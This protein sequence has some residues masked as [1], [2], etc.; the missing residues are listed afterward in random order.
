[1]HFYVCISVVT[2]YVN[3][4]YYI[5]LLLFECFV[6]DLSINAGTS[7]NK[8]EYRT[9]ICILKC[10]KEKLAYTHVQIIRTCLPFPRNLAI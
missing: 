8:Y 2:L 10:F 6:F 4:L 9:C 3:Q 1:M 7:A 5:L